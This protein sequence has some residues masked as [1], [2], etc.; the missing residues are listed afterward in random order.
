VA[1]CV[2]EGR[3]P[4]GEASLAGVSAWSMVHGLAQLSIGGRLGARSGGKAP[5]DLGERVIDLFVKR[6]M[7]ARAER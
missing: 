5:H 4:A 6:L 1:A 3:L 7:G 2:A